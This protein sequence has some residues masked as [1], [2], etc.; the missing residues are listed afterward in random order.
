[1]EI[2]KRIAIL[3]KKNKMTQKELADK[4][5]VSDKAI[6]SWEAGR[7]EPSLELVVKLSEILD[8][9]ASYLLYG[10][11]LKNDIETEIKIKLT[12]EE[13]K[14]LQLLVEREAIFVK[15]NHQI[16]TYF[17]P[18]Y[19]KFVKDNKEDSINE[20]LRIGERGNKIILN[21]KNWYDHYCDEYEVEVDDSINLKKIFK[22]LGLE[23]IAY[24]DKIRRI[25]KYK[26]KYEISLD[27]VKELGYFV[28]IE[29]KKY[30]KDLS[31]EYDELLK[32][33]KNFGL[34]LNNI[35]RRGYPYY[36]VYKN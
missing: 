21:Y 22:V 29:I 32:V 10:D 7:T 25:Y 6:S 5:F 24:V 11:V 26:D 31:L 8:C 3:R 28:E 16:D 34:N 19:R 36:M 15:E 20:W 35:D 17:Q 18:S 9:R 4:L 12:K 33:A 1:M 14:N 23:E 13:Y 30:N 2:G 27:I